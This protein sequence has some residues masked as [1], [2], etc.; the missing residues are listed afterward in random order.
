MLDIAGRRKAYED[1]LRR[2]PAI[3]ASAIVD[4]GAVIGTFIP[5]QLPPLN[6]SHPLYPGLTR[7][8]YEVHDSD[9]FALTRILGSTYGKVGVLNL[10]SDQEPSGG[11]H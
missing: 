1:T 6:R 9:A 10:A 5:R 4:S 7:K 3:A 11:W 8:P 2:T